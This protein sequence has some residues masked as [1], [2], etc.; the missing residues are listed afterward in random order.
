[1]SLPKQAPEQNQLSSDCERLDEKPSQRSKDFA[2]RKWVPRDT[3]EPLKRLRWYYHELMRNMHAHDKLVANPEL[4]IAF[5]NKYD[6][7]R[8]E[9]PKWLEQGAERISKLKRVQLE[10]LD[11]YM[12]TMYQDIWDYYDCD[13]K[14]TFLHDQK[15]RTNA[16]HVL[17]VCCTFADIWNVSYLFTQKLNSINDMVLFEGQ[18]RM[19]SD[20]LKAKA[21]DVILRKRPTSTT[22]SLNAATWFTGSSMEGILFVHHVRDS[23]IKMLVVQELASRSFPCSW[24]ECEI[25]IQPGITITV[26]METSDC[27]DSWHQNCS[28]ERI[29][30]NP[31]LRVLHT[32][33][34]CT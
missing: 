16:A 7:W 29:F 21:G 14:C 19:E 30:S 34:S 2:D 12:S 18:G 10:A 32:S 4:H 22:W 15:F 9:M 25:L 24:L 33:I 11:G 17:R 26:D 23:T 8:G 6:L 28:D 3:L 27:L 20:A 5:L 1:M 13:Q 31:H